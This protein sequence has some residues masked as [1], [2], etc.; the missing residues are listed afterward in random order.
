MNAPRNR[1]YRHLKTHKIAGA[2]GAK[3]SDAKP[4]ALRGSRP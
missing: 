3:P 4:Q 1:Q 2:L